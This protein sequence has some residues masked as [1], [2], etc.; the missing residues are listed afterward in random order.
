MAITL[1]TVRPADWEA[2]RR[3]IVRGGQRAAFHRRD[4]AECPYPYDSP[5]GEAWVEGYENTAN[6]DA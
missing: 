4:I 5:E 6:A 3:E 1:H 2:R